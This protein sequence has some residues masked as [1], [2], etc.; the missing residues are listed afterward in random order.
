MKTDKNTII[1]KRL[2]SI[3]KDLVADRIITAKRRWQINRIRPLDES[4]LSIELV[5]EQL[6]K[7]AKMTSWNEFVNSQYSGECQLIAQTVSIMFPAIQFYSVTIN[8]SEHA[9]S[10]M[11]KLD[12]PEMYKCTHFFNMYNGQYIDFGKGTNRYENIYVLDGIDDMYSCTYSSKAIQHFSDIAEKS[13]SIPL[14]K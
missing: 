5:Q 4:N 3:A 11:K 2:V 6:L 14:S 9:I 12:N 8:F 10:Q 13:T 7:L 1:A